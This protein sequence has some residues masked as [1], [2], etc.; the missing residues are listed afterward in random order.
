MPNYL[1]TYAV[2]MYVWP[3]HV[4][5]LLKCE[6][7]NKGI[8]KHFLISFGRTYLPRQKKEEAKKQKTKQNKS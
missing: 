8:Q 4:K 3:L 5:V 1:S 2:H 7:T 6:I